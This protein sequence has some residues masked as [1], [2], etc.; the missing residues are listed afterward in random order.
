VA[1]INPLHLDAGSYQRSPLHADDRMWSETNCY[2]DLWIELLHALGLDPVPALAFTLSTDFEG[3]QFQFFKFPAEDLRAMY[4]IEVAEMN[5]WRSL[6]DHISDQLV[7]GRFLTL[8][9]DSFHLPDTAGVS[10]GIEHVKSSIVPAMIDRDERR[11]G[12]FHGPSY[13]VLEGDDFTGALRLEADQASLPPYVELIR[14]ERL[15]RPAPDELHRRALA[16]VAAHLERRPRTNPVERFHE[17]F[18]RDLDWLRSQ[19]LAVF[20]TYAFVSL[21]Q[22]G[23]G[24]ELAASLCSWLTD[25]GESIAVGAAAF[26][27][28]A[29]QAK[30]AQFKLARLAMG[31][32][33]D[34]G[35]LI[36]EMAATWQ[37][38]VDDLEH[39]LTA[40]PTGA[41]VR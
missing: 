12:Y 11:L 4:G 28:L 16:L 19:D 26:A 24:S 7:A 23:A 34:V 5:P 37:R 27:D 41:D 2:A 17:Q 1:V 39:H 35:P 10:Y 15:E 25:R 6:V 3:D 21:R 8:E 14:L 33:G 32:S 9:A 40:R 30:A 20:H 18:E 29:S 38:A 22:L 13:F 36:D 31:R